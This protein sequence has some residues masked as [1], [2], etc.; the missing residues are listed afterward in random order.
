MLKKIRSLTGNNKTIALNVMGA[1]VVRGAALILSLFTMP[2]YLRF[3]NDNTTLGIWYT[4]LS[5][6]NW[7]LMFDLGLGNG[8]RNK[9]PACMIDKD[10]QKAKEYISSTYAG[11]CMVVLAWALIGVVVIRFVHWNTFL[12]IDEQ[13]V[14]SYALR[15]SIS[16]TFGGVM[17]QFVLKTITS[18][19]YALQKSAVVNFLQLITS[20]LTLILVSVIPSV[21]TEQNLIH[22]AIVNAVAANIPFLIATILVFLTELK[23][24]APHLKDVSI[25]RIKEVLNIGITLLWLTLVTMVISSTNELLITKMTN[26]SNVVYFQVYFKIFNTI[27]SVFALA[28]APIWSAVTKASAEKQY[29]W[30]RKLYDRLLT[31]ALGVF[32]CELLVIPFMQIL[33]NIWLGKNYIKVDYG[34]AAVFAVSSSIFFLHNVNTSVGNG[35]SFFQ[36]QKKWMTFAAIIDIPLAWIFVKLTGS[37]VGIIVAN[38]LALLPFETI[39]ILGFKKMIK[40]RISNNNG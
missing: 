40:D 15:T 4:I 22:M 1:F 31:M 28:L 24:Y 35:M 11:T 36:I 2:A 27:S 21:G 14:S 25:G 18:I 8:L 29:S 16:I 30:I 23:G 38:I 3:F 32:A 12:N 10:R 33:V 6:L 39:E 26:S 7:V 5:V 34:I 13:S 20:A 9:L 17:L 37:W 19:L